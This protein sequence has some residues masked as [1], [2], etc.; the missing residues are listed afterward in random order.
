MS[1]C[2]RLTL[3]PI[4]WCKLLLNHLPS[5]VCLHGMMFRQKINSACNCIHAENGHKHCNNLKQQISTSVVCSAVLKLISEC[6]IHWVKKKAIRYC[7][8]IFLQFVIFVPWTYKHIYHLSHKPLADGV[9]VDSSLAIKNTKSCN[10]TSINQCQF[11]IGS[12]SYLN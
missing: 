2:Q 12:V 4:Q 9:P 1:L 7:C 5:S 3:G 11:L 10:P 8:V 6:C